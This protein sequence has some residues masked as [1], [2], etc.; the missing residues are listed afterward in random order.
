M[1]LY[2]KVRPKSFKQIVGQ[3]Y[4][5]E[6][7][8]I[9]LREHRVPHDILF[10]GPSGCGKT[11]WARLLRKKIG[12]GKPDCHE[13]NAAD[14]KGIDMVRDIRNRMGLMPTSGSCR[15]WI[16]DECHKLTSDAQSALLKIL[17]DT[18]EHVY[19]FLCTTDPTK[20]ISTIRTRCTEIR[21]K[22][23]QRDELKRVMNNACTQETL[24]DIPKL[25]MD[26]IAEQS[27]GS[28]RKALVF[29][30]QVAHMKNPQAMLDLIERGSYES[31]AIKICRSLFNVR[32]KWPDMVKVIDEV[33]KDNPESLRWLVLSYAKSVL[34]SGGKLSGRAFLVI[35][36]FRDNWFD[37]KD[38][39][40]YAG[41]YEVLV[42]SK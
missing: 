22:T 2:V 31:D 8:K 3:K 42:G 21:V 19:F 32:T 9:W 15:V 17:E 41:C 4:I 11:T 10:T 12:C 5:T 30:H 36:A 13:V 18:P 24:G 25:V 29:L 6:M 37:C 34:R 33:N 7:V 23:L 14:A 20:L 16:I 28:A 27:D 39:G 38:V 26:K 40:L 35:Q 1:D